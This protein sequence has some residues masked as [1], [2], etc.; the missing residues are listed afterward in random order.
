MMQGIRVYH[1][2]RGRPNTLEAPIAP[3]EHDTLASHVTDGRLVAAPLPVLAMPADATGL[4]R[5]DRVGVQGAARGWVRRHAHPD[6]RTRFTRV[7][8]RRLE[9]AALRPRVTAT[10]L[11][12]EFHT[13][14]RGPAG[15]GSASARRR[16]QGSV[17]GHAPLRPRA[18][19]EGAAGQVARAVFR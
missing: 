7:S 1:P 19:R 10:V 3:E 8:A 12:E 6:R 17:R 15:G 13:L 2:G 9:A 4:A 5:D 16:D 14:L 18:L 11:P